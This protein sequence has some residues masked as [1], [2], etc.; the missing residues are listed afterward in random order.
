[1]LFFVNLP[2]CSTKSF[3]KMGLQAKIM[4]SVNQPKYKIDK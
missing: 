3:S 1:M 4:D 2:K